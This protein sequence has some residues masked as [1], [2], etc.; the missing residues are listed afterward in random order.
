MDGCKIAE[1]FKNKAVELT[2]SLHAKFPVQLCLPMMMLQNMEPV[3]AVE[4]YSESVHRPY[5]ARIRS[6]D[7]TFFMTDDL[8]NLPDEV[9]SSMLTMVR[10]LWNDLSTE[11]Q[12]SVWDYFHIFERLATAYEKWTHS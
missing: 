11:E 6:R 3:V 8:V 7:V 5:E 2:Q 4:R 12:E 9:D 10:G 1:M